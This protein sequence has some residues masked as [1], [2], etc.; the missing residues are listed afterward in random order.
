MANQRGLSGLPYIL[1]Y[2]AGFFLLAIIIGFTA[3]YIFGPDLLQNEEAMKKALALE[4]FAVLFEVLLFIYLRN[5]IGKAKV[6]NEED[7]R[8]EPPTPPKEKKDLS[9]FR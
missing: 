2:L 6:R 5:K 1:N 3:M 4:P 9:Y 8:P 7:D